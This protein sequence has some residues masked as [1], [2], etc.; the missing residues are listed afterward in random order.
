M[1][2]LFKRM[3]SGALCAI[4][5][6]CLSSCGGKGSSDGEFYGDYHDGYVDGYSDGV[7]EAQQSISFY[8][9]DD[10]YEINSNNEK[11][12]GLSIEDAVQILRNY[13]DGEPISEAELHN[14]IWSINKFYYDTCDIVYNIEN[15]SLD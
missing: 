10:F 8:V 6:F 15:Y 9:E 2:K 7:A 3:L 1:S 11:E 5:I 12:R 4:L 13:A 14:A